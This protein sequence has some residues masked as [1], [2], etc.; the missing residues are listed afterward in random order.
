MSEEAKIKIYRSMDRL[1]PEA[2]WRVI[3]VRAEPKIIH[4]IVPDAR[5]DSG[6]RIERRLERPE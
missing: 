5:A 2:G 1:H 3:T 6:Y 4:Y